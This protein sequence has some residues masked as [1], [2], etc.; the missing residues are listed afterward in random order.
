MTISAVKGNLLRHDI[1][2]RPIRFNP[3][4]LHCLQK[5]LIEFTHS[6]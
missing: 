6:S 4:N 5:I 1:T 3:E 2:I